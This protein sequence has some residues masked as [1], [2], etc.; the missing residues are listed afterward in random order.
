LKGFGAQLQ[1]CLQSWIFAQ[2]RCFTQKRADFVAL[3][4]ID[5]VEWNSDQFALL[6]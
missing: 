2:F 5:L 3:F 6:S 1:V 4:A